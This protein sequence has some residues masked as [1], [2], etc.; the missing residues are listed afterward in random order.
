LG[1]GVLPEKVGP[2]SPGYPGL[3]R[4]TPRKNRGVSIYIRPEFLAEPASGKLIGQES[5]FEGCFL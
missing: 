1:F 2:G 4:Q 5:S 3:A